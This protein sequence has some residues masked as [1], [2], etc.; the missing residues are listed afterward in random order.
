MKKLILFTFL[1][2]ITSISCTKTITKIVVEKEIV[3]LQKKDDTLLRVKLPKK[4]G[5]LHQFKIFKHDTIFYVEKDTINRK[6]AFDE[7]DSIYDVKTTFENKHIKVGKYYEY[8]QKV[9]T[10]EVVYKN[11]KGLEFDYS[12]KRLTQR[13]QDYKVSGLARTKHNLQFFRSHDQKNP[14]YEL[15]FYKDALD[16]YEK[17]NY[18]LTT[19]F[20]CCTSLPEYQIFDL[21]G[22]FIFFSN[23]L[24]KRINTKYSHYLISVLKNE[25][26]DPITVIIQNRNKIKQYVTLSMKI[27]NYQFGENYFVKI[28]NKKNYEQENKK[29][30]KAYTLNSLDDL[31]I[32]IPF[33]KADT[34]KI[35]FLNEKAFGVDY[36]QI[37]VELVDGK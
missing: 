32:W 6:P 10:A 34:L 23:N 31:E 35:P 21:K 5:N 15:N 37:K 9:E 12:L 18:L 28:K 19:M 4:N 22:N 2:L 7:I 30:L 14:A 26:F 25:V 13:Y 11:D 20:G 17:E 1:A 29:L 24:I 27:H 3:F 16:I 33:G 36:P 8:I